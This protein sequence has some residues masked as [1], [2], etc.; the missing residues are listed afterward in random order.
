M[1]NIFYMYGLMWIIILIMYAFGWS[2]L[3]ITLD[4]NLLTFLIFTIVV[5]LIV[6]YFLRKKLRFYKLE[7]NPHK[8]RLLT[9]ILLVFF[10]IDIIYEGTI[11]LLAVLKGGSMYDVPFVGIPWLHMIATGISF[12]YCLYLAYIYICFKQKTVILEYLSILSFFVLLFQRQNIIMIVLLSMLLFISSIKFDLSWKSVG[13]VAGFI[14]AIM[15]V[16]FIFGV[17]GNVRYGIWGWNDSSMICE[18]AQINDKY[19]DFLPKQYVWAYIYLVSPLANLN[20]NIVLGNTVINPSFFEILYSYL[21]DFVMSMIA[22]VNII[23]NELLT[24]ALTVCTAFATVFRYQGIFGMYM[25]Y[26]YIMT[27]SVVMVLLI[28]KVK[29]LHITFVIAIGYFLLFT[30]FTNPVVYPITAMMI[31]FCF[32]C[33]LFY[34]LNVIQYLN[35]I[36]KH[37]VN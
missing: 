9:Y 28:S 21:P 30:F 4:P 3:L 20:Y 12:V 33:Y 14:I 2:D 16:L 7:N 19:P 29:H 26:V 18:V 1:L 13:I 35:K 34:R 23:G 31:I 32:V 22:N 37:F 10:A 17:I 27:L 15:I 11:P 24:P 6:G 25:L 36:K 8:S 5:S